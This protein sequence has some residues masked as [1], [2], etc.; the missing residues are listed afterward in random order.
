MKKLY[1][2]LVVWSTVF[3]LALLISMTAANILISSYAIYT[4]ESL[5]E[6]KQVYCAILLGTSKWL[7]GGRR[8][9]YYQYRIIAAAELYR[10]GKCKKIIVSGDN[11]TIQYNEPMTMKRDLVKMGI[12]E[13]DVICDYA[14][15]RTLDS[16]IR[17]KEIFG[18]KEGIVVSQQFHNTRAVYIGRSYGIELHGYNAND[19]TVYYGFKTKLREVLSKVMCV[20]DVHILYT[21]P[22]F[23]GEKVSVGE[24]KETGSIL[25]EQK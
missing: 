17:F 10:S 9:L 12:K 19:V 13:E 15:F 3:L 1:K 6:L 21:Q 18:Q 20:L 22:K 16:I 23:L 25:P 24:E 5:S 11:A 4:T 14:G 7:K 2:R 8:N